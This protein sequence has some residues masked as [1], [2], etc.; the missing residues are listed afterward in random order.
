MA[1]PCSLNKYCNPFTHVLEGSCNKRKATL[2]FLEVA[3]LPQN[4]LGRQKEEG[5]I[6]DIL[7]TSENVVAP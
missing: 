1:T 3:T 5:K 4:V 6:R 2:W 7:T